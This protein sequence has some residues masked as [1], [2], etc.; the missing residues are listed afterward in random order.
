MIA[1]QKQ[2]ILS[3]HDIKGNINT[4]FSSVNN[5]PDDIEKIQIGKLNLPEHGKIAIK[6]MPF[7]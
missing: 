2:H 1:A 7:R 4:L 3:C 5:I 6:K